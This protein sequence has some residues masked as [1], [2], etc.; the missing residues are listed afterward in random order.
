MILSVVILQEGFHSSGPRLNT[1]A[2][3]TVSSPY[4]DLENPL[5]I[6][7]SLSAKI[8]ILIQGMR[9]VQ[10]F[11]TPHLP[12]TGG[13]SGSVIKPSLPLTPPWSLLCSTAP[14]LNG[15]SILVISLPSSHPDGEQNTSPTQD[16]KGYAVIINLKDLKNFIPYSY[17]NSLQVQNSLYNIF[18]SCVGSSSRR[19]KAA[20]GWKGK[21]EQIDASTQK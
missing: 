3:L 2:P 19:A 9:K 10:L 21:H 16:R 1:M 18:L 15:M 4:H 17:R 8:C 11:V 20:A 6:Q 5:D 12:V 14:M 7:I 13:Q